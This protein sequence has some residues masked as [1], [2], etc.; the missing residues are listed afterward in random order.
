MY[1]NPILK[2]EAKTEGQFTSIAAIH[3]TVSVTS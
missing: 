1:E 2:K 3:R